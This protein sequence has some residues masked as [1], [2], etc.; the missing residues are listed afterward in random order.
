MNTATVRELDMVKEQIPV[1]MIDFWIRYLS[2]IGVTQPE[3]TTYRK[4]C[5]EGWAPTPTNDVQ[6]AI[7]DRIHATP[8]NPMKIEFDP[9][10]GR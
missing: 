7:W 6:K 1:D 2:R 9:K 3:F 8:K 10:K 4:A 5:K